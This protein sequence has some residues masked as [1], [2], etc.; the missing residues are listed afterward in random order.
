MK[1]KLVPARTGAT[2]VKLGMK[3]FFRQPLALAGLFFIF[4]AVMSVAAMLPVL[5]L[6]LA[7]TLLPPHWG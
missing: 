2:W 5:G 6:P 4:M 7:M 1:L 3:T